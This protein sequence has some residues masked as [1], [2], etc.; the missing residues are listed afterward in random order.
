MQRVHVRAA[1]LVLPRAQVD[2][3]QRRRA[4]DR[5]R[6]HRRQPRRAL[7]GPPRRQAVGAHETDEGDAR[8]RPAGAAGGSL[9][10]DA[11]FEVHKGERLCHDDA[12]PTARD[13]RAG[14]Q[15]AAERDRLLARSGVAD[16]EHLVLL[17]PEE[18]AAAVATVQRATAGAQPRERDEERLGVERVGTRAAAVAA[19]QPP[20]DGARRVGGWRSDAARRRRRRPGAAAARPRV[21]QPV[22]VGADV[23]A[24]VLELIVRHGAVEV[25]KAA[26]AVNDGLGGERRDGV[27][28]RDSRGR[29]G[30]RSLRAAR[31]STT[32][33][34]AAASLA[35]EAAFAAVPA[36]AAAAAAALI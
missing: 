3:E 34:T 16:K 7:Y 23:H 11:A 17:L 24:A 26:Q 15:Q 31:T 12:E 10:V 32:A 8:D 5:L 2:D 30:G 1:V 28:G 22:K 36:A 18:A 14:S 29:R 9:S 20:R 25:A 4:R 35:L 13:R 33:A 21:P 19:R 6:Q 27:G